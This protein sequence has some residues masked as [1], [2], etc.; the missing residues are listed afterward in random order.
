MLLLKPNCEW[1]DRD[2]P[3]KSSHAMICSYECTY[4]VDCAKNILRNVCPTCGGNLC[5]RPIRPSISH[6][7]ELSLGLEFHPATA[8]RKHSRWRE[9]QVKALVQKL[10]SIPPEDR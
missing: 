5:P 7:E 10:H 2:L 1:C 6:R 4:C 9:E 8:E 3:A